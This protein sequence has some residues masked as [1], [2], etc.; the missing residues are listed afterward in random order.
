MNQIN[1]LN[2][3]K[4]QCDFKSQLII[5]L[6]I[7]FLL[8]ITGCSYISQNINQKNDLIYRNFCDRWL[9]R[10]ISDDQILNELRIYDFKNLNEI[11]IL[12][13]EYN[14][15]KNDKEYC[16]DWLNNRLNDK[17]VMLKFGYIDANKGL[18]E[19]KSICKEY[20][21]LIER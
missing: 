4:I 20:K 2:L 1:I 15:L 16:G 5:S 11:K 21:Y 7:I 12:C 6:K 19:I 8:S 9:N 10:R 17:E 18:N 3:K 13:K 14:Y